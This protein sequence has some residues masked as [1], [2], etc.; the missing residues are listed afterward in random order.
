[1]NRTVQE[2]YMA[3]TSTPLPCSTTQDAHPCWLLKITGA[4]RAW[5]LLHLVI[6][7]LLRLEP[8]YGSETVRMDSYPS[9]ALPF[10]VF[11]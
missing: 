10:Y 6:H 2:F 11:G 8:L 1:M 9:V 3:H 5:I 7:V 4:T